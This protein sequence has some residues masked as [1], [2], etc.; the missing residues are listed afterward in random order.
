[1]PQV[2]ARAGL[3]PSS[4][5]LIQRADGT[6]RVTYHGRPLYL[7][8]NEQLDATNPSAPLAGNGDRTKP[9]T[10]RAGAFALVTNLAG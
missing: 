5:G 7:Y 1:L 3:N 8:A 9:S 6:H 2:A 10:R 4:L